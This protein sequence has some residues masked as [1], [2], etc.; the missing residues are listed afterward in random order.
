MGTAA[1][2][3]SVWSRPGRLGLLAIVVVLL[4]TLPSAPRWVYFWDTKVKLQIAANLVE[5][6]GAVI[7]DPTP[8]D[9]FFV[10]VGRDGRRVSH[11]PILACLGW[12]PTYWLVKLGGPPIGGLPTLIALAALCSILAAWGLRSGLRP[13]IALGGAFLACLGSVLWPSSAFEYDSVADAVGLG[14]LLW[15]A[16]G[17]RLR[18][19][20]VAGATLGLVLC[21]RQTSIIL[22]AP[23]LALA[24]A[25]A[26]R[27]EWWRRVLVAGVAALPGVAA[28]IAWNYYA[29]GT[30]I[31]TGSG[32]GRYLVSPF[33]ADYW[34]A[35]LG[36]IASPGKGV[37]F[38]SPTLLA[39][40]FVLPA[41]VRRFRTAVVGLA[42]FALASVLVY[43]RFEFWTG[44]WA[45][46]PRYLM[47]WAVAAAPL[48]W[49]AAE[50][51]ERRGASARAAA[52]A[53]GVGLIA[54]QA[55]PIAAGAVG[56]YIRDVAL[57]LQQAGVLR[58]QRILEQV[59]KEDARALYFDVRRSSIVH[60]AQRAVA[61]L[62]AGGR[63]RDRLL[64]DL[65]AACAAPLAALLAFLV[66]VRGDLLPRRGKA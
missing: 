63:V 18:D 51:V 53:V 61:M 24:L 48:A 4:G 21:T 33:T 23:A 38:Y 36:F 25:Q 34:W 47:G 46:G 10:H 59:G 19:W 9:S 26:P 15:A 62:R 52:V 45:W 49:L 32:I 42:A 27:A 40:P 43:A 6:R 55:A 7:T 30:P 57:P 22:A 14:V 64:A 56:F 66:V 2:P 5:G 39:L 8:N 58:T 13:A 3:T 44:D 41:L 12:L 54:L 1:S 17:T 60:L 37:L 28:T 65:V 31:W 35:V 50:W 29:Y 20:A 16:A 11:Y